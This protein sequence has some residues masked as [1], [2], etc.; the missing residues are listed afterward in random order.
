MGNYLLTTPETVAGGAAP[1]I[2]RPLQYYA[3]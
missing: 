3:S 2:I 1:P